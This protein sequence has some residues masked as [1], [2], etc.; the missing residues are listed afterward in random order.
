MNSNIR[1]ATKQDAHSFM[2]IKNRLPIKRTDGSTTTG[3]F[4]LGTD[5][6]TYAYYIENAFCLVAEVDGNVVGF[7][8]VFTD[9]MLRESDVWIRREQASW[10]I[11]LKEYEEKR[12]CYFE[13]LAFLSGHRKL[14]IRL[15]YNLVK[16]VFDHHYDALFTTTV[17][18]PVVNLAAIPFI[19]I[20]SGIKAGNIDEVYPLVGDINSDIYVID[21]ENFYAKTKEHAL[22]PYIKRHSIA[23]P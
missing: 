21:A 1:I 3:G 8:I 15:A 10:Y 22:Y 20:V 14:V 11:S 7:G 13:Q 18:K 17:N 5:L 12:I 9:K 23:L 6:K 16:W 19:R 2:E 4:L